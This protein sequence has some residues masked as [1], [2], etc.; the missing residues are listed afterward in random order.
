[1]DHEVVPRPCRIWNCLLKS[2]PDHFGLHQGKM[3]IMTMDFEVPKSQILKPTLFINKV[4][5][6]LWWERQKRYYGRKMLLQWIL[7]EFFLGG[8]G[9]RIFQ[10]DFLFQNCHF[11]AYIKKN[12]TFTFWVHGHSS[13]ST[14]SLHLVRGSK[15]L[16]IDF[17][18]RKS[19]HGR[20]T[21][22][23]RGDF[24]A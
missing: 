3:V 1:M 5:H 12:S 21:S 10:L 7:Y 19:D 6:V 9:K 14:F 18:F 15:A 22:H 8:E 2:S 24:G 20:W 17:L 11:W 13:W 23:D 16:R 4:Q